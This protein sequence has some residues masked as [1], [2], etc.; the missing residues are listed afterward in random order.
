MTTGPGI[1][2]VFVILPTGQLEVID[3]AHV[4]SIRTFRPAE[5]PSF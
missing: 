4:T 3:T 1:L 2:S 5:L